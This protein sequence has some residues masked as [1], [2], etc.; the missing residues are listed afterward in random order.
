MSG[1]KQ[2]C[3]LQW[4]CLVMTAADTSVAVA[5]F[6][7]FSMNR[8]KTVQFEVACLSNGRDTVILSMR[9]V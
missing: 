9:T 1:T 4:S 5:A 3:D 2:Q 6:V 8:C 7:I